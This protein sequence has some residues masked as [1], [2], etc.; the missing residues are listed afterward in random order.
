MCTSIGIVE[1]LHLTTIVGVFLAGSLTIGHSLVHLVAGI[2]HGLHVFLLQILLGEPRDLV[3]G[4]DLA[5]GE[6][7]LRQLADDAEEQLAGIDNGT[8][9]RVR[10]ACCSRQRD[11]GEEGG[12][13]GLRIIEC[14]LHSMVGHTDIR[15]I[16]QHAGRHAKMQVLVIEHALFGLTQC[17]GMMQG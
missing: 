15:T 14:L 11:A 4:I 17:L 12:A 10:P 13:G 6:D 16:L 7:G 1:H 5:S 9:G 3:V 8:A 2:D